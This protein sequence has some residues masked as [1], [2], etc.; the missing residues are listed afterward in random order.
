M[1]IYRGIVLPTGF[2]LAGVV[3]LL[4]LVPGAVHDGLRIIPALVL[5]LALIALGVHRILLLRRLRKAA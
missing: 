2:I 1:L 5:G 3:L 4:R